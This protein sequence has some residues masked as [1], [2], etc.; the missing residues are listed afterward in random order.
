MTGLLKI[1]MMGY[2][3]EPSET[4]PLYPQI[5]IHLDRL[6]QLKSGSEI[7]VGSNYERFPPQ[8]IQCVRLH[9]P[10]IKTMS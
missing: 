2:E 10:L 1:T 9:S 4:K 8:P 5:G 3:V 6:Q 7:T